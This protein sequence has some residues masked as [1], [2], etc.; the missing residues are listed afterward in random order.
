MA[1]RRLLR[2]LLKPARVGIALGA[3]PSCARA[4]DRGPAG[5][6]GADKG[7]AQVDQRG[8]HVAVADE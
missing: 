4:F 6:M 7:D 8:V 5:P 2:R 3:V 1:R